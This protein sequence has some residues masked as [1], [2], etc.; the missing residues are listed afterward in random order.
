MTTFKGKKIMCPYCFEEFDHDQV[1]FRLETVSNEGYDL[2][3]IEHERDLQKKA[4]MRLSLLFQPKDDPQYVKFWSDYGGTTELTTNNERTRYACEVYQLP[5]IDPNSSDAQQCLQLQTHKDGTS[6][7]FT[8]DGYGMV[9][10]VE[11]VHGRRTHRRVCPHCH[12]PLPNGYGKNKTKFIS[13]IG[14]TGSGKTVYISQLMLKIA[15]YSSN[16]LKMST[17][18]KDDRVDNFINNNQV[19]KDVPLPDSTM[20]GRLAQPMTYDI[21]NPSG[22]HNTI[23]IYDIAGENCKDATEMERYGDFVLHSDGIILLISPKQLGFVENYGDQNES[24]G[25]NQD[26]APPRTVLETIYNTIVEKQQ[27]LCEIP[28]AVCISKSDFFA[29]SLGEGE[30]NGADIVKYATNDVEPARRAG[31]DE[32]IPAFNATQYNVIE[33]KIVKMLDGNPIAIDL[34]NEYKYYNYFIFS[35][36]G[37]D[38]KKEVRDDKVVSFPID[39]P[40][41]TRIVEPLLWIFKRFGY[42]KSDV[43][44]RLPHRRGDPN[45]KIPL[46]PTWFQRVILKKPEFRSLT[47]K[48]KE[49]LWY[50]ETC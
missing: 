12:N 29:P 7:Y 28:I 4:E 2:S 22:E 33:K 39:D 17:H 1:H 21:V 42:I 44:I 31:T 15:E 11:D 18:K 43:P 16:L 27:G 8:Y 34:E 45:K 9:Q 36:I 48:E 30:E 37:C 38:V 19:L 35:A 41:P 25:A 50:E 26:A 14:V 40:N 32:K 49:A 13:V 46:N 10:G 3:D 6:N 5:I 20:A 23:V 24:L 47:E